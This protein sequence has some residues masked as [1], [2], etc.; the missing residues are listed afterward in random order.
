MNAI[1]A[2]QSLGLT[3]TDAQIVATLQTLS[4]SNIAAS[5]VRRWLRQDRDPALLA[6]DGSAWFGTLQDM[7]QAGQLSTGMQAGLRD[8]KAL[9]LEGGDLRTTQPGPAGRVYAVVTGIAQILGGD[10]SETIDSFYRLDGGRPFKDLT[11]EQFATQ[12]SDAARTSAADAWAASAL[13][14]TIQPA[15][16]DPARTIETVKAAF[17]AAATVQS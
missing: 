5:S 1:E 10:Q 6:Y 8:L 7:L 4:R 12:K 15:M 9:M 2:A 16:S 14:E 17:L 3:G 11:A 13:N